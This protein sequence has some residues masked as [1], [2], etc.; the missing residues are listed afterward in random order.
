MRRPLK[1]QMKRYLILIWVIGMASLTGFHILNLWSGVSHS[2]SALDQDQLLRATQIDFNN[3]DPFYRLSV[4]HQWDLDHVDL[5]K[6]YAYLQQAIDR[7]PLEQDY[8]LHL[9]IIFQKMDKREDSER[10]LEKA[11]SVFPTGYRGRWVAGNLLLQQGS[12]EKAL[13]H[14][15]YILAHYP[16]ESRFIYDLWEAVVARDSDFI[17]EKLIPK[18]IPTL[19]QYLTYLYEKRE[20]GKA[21]KVRRLKESLGDQSNRNGRTGHD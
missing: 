11:V 1:F 17:L 8:W 13:P 18:E 12:P 5:R 4:L 16:D 20:E 14:F 15:S 3:P 2:W 21:Q 9:A 19:H 6:S 7:N 10:A